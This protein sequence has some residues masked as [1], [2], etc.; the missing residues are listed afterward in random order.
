[1]HSTRVYNSCA[2]ELKLI[3]QGISFGANDEARDISMMLEEV[4]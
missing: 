2:G 3:R 4:P 1:M